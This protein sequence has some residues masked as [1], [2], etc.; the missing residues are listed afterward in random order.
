VAKTDIGQGKQ[1]LALGGGGVTGYTN[2][3]GAVTYTATTVTPTASPSWTVSTTSNFANANVWTGFICA[4]GGGTSNAIVYGVITSNTA[5]ALTVDRWYNPASPTG[6]A[7]TTPAA[8]SSF[9]IIPGNAPAWYMGITTGSVAITDTS[10]ASEET[11][12]GLGRAPAT[13]AHTFSSSS[14]N[15]TYTLTNTFTY[16][17]S[18][19]KVLNAIGTFD[20]ASNGVPLFTT[21]LASTATVN[22]SGDTCTVT[23]TITM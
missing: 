18:S 4:A 21:A 1:A 3:S 8:N 2:N 16:T 5:T 11:T 12:N 6:A 14:A 10:L 15:N 13:F 22:A 23:Q 19:S 20:A 7:A 17:G 9:I